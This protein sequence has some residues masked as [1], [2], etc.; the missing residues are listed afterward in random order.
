VFEAQHSRQPLQRENLAIIAVEHPP[1]TR[2]WIGRITLDDLPHE[3]YE[4]TENFRKAERI[5]LEGQKRELTVGQAIN[6]LRQIQ[7]LRPYGRF[8]TSRPMARALFTNWAEGV[9]APALWA[10]TPE[11]RVRI[12]AVCD[13]VFERSLPLTVKQVD[14]LY[15]KTQ[16]LNLGVEFDV[17]HESVAKIPGLLLPSAQTKAVARRM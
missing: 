14:E 3:G 8:G 7:E 17:V 11:S 12:L 5:I 15:Q 2:R 13:N 1:L 6:S 10:M 16:W 4:R 9:L